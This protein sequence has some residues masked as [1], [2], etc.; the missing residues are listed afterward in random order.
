MLIDAGLIVALLGGCGVVFLVLSARRVARGRLL[1]GA[2]HGLAGL[3]CAA[4]AVALFALAANF[5]TYGR[6]TYER[7]VATLTFEAMAAQ[8]YRVT[9]E[10]PEDAPA[11]VF[12]IRGD[13]WQIDARILKWSGI[14]N[15]LGLDA[16][17]RLDRLSGRYANITHERTAARTV[18]ALSDNPGLDLWAAAQRYQRWLPLADA[19]YGSATYLPMADGA[20]FVVTITQ[21][22]VIARP[23]NDPARAAVAAWQ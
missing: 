16:N 18:Y 3:T 21:A 15:V 20:R 19:S 22:G 13:Q 4:M 2:G 11:E 6:L 8:R 10:Q 17:Y 23:A 9:L 5:H 14:A 12:E 1:R 7:D